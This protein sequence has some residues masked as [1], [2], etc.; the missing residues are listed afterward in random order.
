MESSGMPAVS[1]FS[2]RAE[3]SHS[4][5]TVILCLRACLHRVRIDRP[6][7]VR[8]LPP[9]IAALVTC[10]GTAPTPTNQHHYHHQHHHHCTVALAISTLFP[11]RCVLDWA[12]KARQ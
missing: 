12:S 6:V 10:T 3:A 2:V 1:P 8:S 5:G 11:A 9:A 7:P 4:E